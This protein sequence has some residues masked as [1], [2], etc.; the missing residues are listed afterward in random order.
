MTDRGCPAV[1]R[2]SQ[3][4]KFAEVWEGPIVSYGEEETGE[5]KISI[6]G[7]VQQILEYLNGFDEGAV[8]PFGEPIINPRSLKSELKSGLR[9]WC[10]NRSQPC[11]AGE[12]KE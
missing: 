5:V 6:V 4:H 3:M 7:G 10:D 12:M 9:A 1:F 2:R 8:T 11:T